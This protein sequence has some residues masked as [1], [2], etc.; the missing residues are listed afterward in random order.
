M[1]RTLKA[2]RQ[3]HVRCQV[4]CSLALL[5][6]SGCSDSQPAPTGVVRFDD[7]QPVQ[8]GKVELRSLSTDMRYAGKIATDGS[9]V[10]QNE[11]GVTGLPAGEY[12][13][14]VVQMVLTE[15]LA[16]DQ[17]QHGRT[18]PRRYADYYTSGLRVT[19]EPQRSD[20][21]AITLQSPPGP[22]ERSGSE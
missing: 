19:N 5:L 17:H 10:L 13:A 20:P 1:G 22:S 16:A 3:P 8:S 9:F 12:E 11:E 18:V 4:L 15:D 14:V 2:R 6:L 21:L 7:G